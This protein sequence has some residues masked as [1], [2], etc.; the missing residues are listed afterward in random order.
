ML[1]RSESRM[2]R[3]ARNQLLFGRDIPYEETAKSIQ[4]VKP[5]AV[6]EMAARLLDPSHRSLALLGP[7]INPEWN[8]ILIP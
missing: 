2:M 4:A 1:F 6:H 7:D 3:L 8:K 5:E